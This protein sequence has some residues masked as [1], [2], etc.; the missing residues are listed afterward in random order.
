[1]GGDPRAAGLIGRGIGV[2]IA[3][4]EYLVIYEKGPTSW[5]AYVPD[6]PGCVAAGK[7]QEEVRELIEGAVDLHLRGMREDGDPIPEP[8]AVAAGFVDTSKRSG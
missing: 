2:A 7:T 8:T 5:G 1:V 4:M 3:V 6:L